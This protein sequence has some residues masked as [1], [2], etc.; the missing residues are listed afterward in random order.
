MKISRDRAY[1]WHGKHHPAGFLVTTR[2]RD[3]LNPN[4]MYTTA[5]WGTTVQKAKADMLHDLGRARCT[6]M[7]EHG[8]RDD[9]PPWWLYQIRDSKGGTGRGVPL[10][11][12]VN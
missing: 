7:Q 11:Q 1:R 6:H 10:I 12:S 8:Y 5:G 2:T 3:P 9:I 4:V